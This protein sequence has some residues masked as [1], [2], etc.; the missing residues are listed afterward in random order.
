MEIIF[1]FLLTFENPQDV[2]SLTLRN[3]E[4]VERVT[5]PT[6]SDCEQALVSYA[7][8]TEPIMQTKSN[9]AGHL[10][11]FASSK[12]NSKF[13]ISCLHIILSGTKNFPLG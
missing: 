12:N 10:E 7:T 6:L 8:Q 4:L 13:K 5:F 11:A 9:N 3:D 1:V 2:S